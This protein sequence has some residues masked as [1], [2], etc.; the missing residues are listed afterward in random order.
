MSSLKSS[1]KAFS[2]LELSIVI[3]CF[4]LLIGAISQSSNIYKKYQLSNA[5][6]L[7]LSSE[8]NGIDGLILWLDATRLKSITNSSNST[9]LK[10]GDLIKSWKSENPQ[11]KNIFD[12]T[13]ANSGEQPSYKEK[14]INGLPS[15]FFD[16]NSNTTTINRLATAHNASLSTAEFTIFAVIQP[17]KNTTEL[18]EIFSFKGS[19]G[20]G[21]A[22]YK[23]NV[24]SN[25]WSFQTWS[26]NGWIET[27]GGEAKLGTATLLTMMR[28]NDSSLIFNNA[29]LAQS[30]IAPYELNS[31]TSSSFFVGSGFDGFISEVIMFDRALMEE[32]RQIV[33]RYLGRKYG[34]KVL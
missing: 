24:T 22:L 29:T 9:N 3:L 26:G 8:I 6:S 12:F 15:L 32:D 33:E 13:Q 11:T 5:R 7:T 27:I 18:G 19:S 30:G 28:N 31:E 4:G 20:L 10:D 14:G 2:L 21:F 25:I 17:I 34:I 16:N 1:P 23:K